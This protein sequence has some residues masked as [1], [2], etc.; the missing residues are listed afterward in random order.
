MKHYKYN[1]NVPSTQKR[2][3]PFAGARKYADALSLIEF[4]F[5]SA[6][7]HIEFMNYIVNVHERENFNRVMP[8]ALAE[9]C[10]RGNAQLPELKEL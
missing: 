9:L 5:N 8:P 3:G 2:H 10:T 6:Q 1:I 7:H 4:C